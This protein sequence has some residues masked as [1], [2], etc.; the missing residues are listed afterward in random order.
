M[1]RSTTK[2]MTLEIYIYISD[3]KVKLRIV[4]NKFITVLYIDKH[5]YFGILT[6]IIPVTYL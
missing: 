3:K 5:R 1:L 2:R 6:D 4:I